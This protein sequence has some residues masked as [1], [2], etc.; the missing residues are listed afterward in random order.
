[1]RCQHVAVVTFVVVIAML[2]H[3]SSAAIRSTADLASSLLKTPKADAK[4]AA[5]TKPIKGEPHLPDT[6]RINPNTF[7][8]SGISAG[9]A[10]AIQF[11]Y[12]FSRIVKGAGIIAGVPYMC[13]QGLMGGAL[14]CMNMPYQIDEATLKADVET[15]AAEGL[16]DDISYIKN[17]TIYLFSGAKDTVVYQG[18][19]LKVLDMMQYFDAYSIRTMFNYSAEHSWITN[20]YGNDCS[21]LGEPYLNNCGLDFA[22]EFLQQSFADMASQNN[23]PGPWNPTRGVFEPLNMVAFDQTFYGASGLISMDSVGYVY[24]PTKCATGAVECHLHVNFHGCNQQRTKVGTQYVEHTGL[25]EWGEANNIVILYP[26]IVA[27][28]LVPL[29]PQGCFDWW[30]YAGD[31]YGVRSGPQMQVIRSMISAL[32]HF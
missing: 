18:T 26:Q 7:T 27:S 3:P 12:A 19:M 31:N 4:K 8:V 24:V 25:N 9:A 30:G 22:G 11:Q 28:D 1:M 20:F 13:A 29:N 32:G 15:F 6:I 23:N 14:D 5:T 16:I 10:M 17:H 2:S 21:Y